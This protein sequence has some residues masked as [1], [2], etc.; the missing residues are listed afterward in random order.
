MRHHT[1]AAVRHLTPLLVWL[2]VPASLGA[3][4]KAAEAVGNA[5]AE[6]GGQANDEP[7]APRL[8]PDQQLGEKLNAYIDC[9][10]RT[11]SSTH[12]AIDQYRRWVDFEQGVTGKEKSVRGIGDLK[13]D[14]RC[15]EG[16][17]AA[18]PLPPADAELDAAADAWIL[19][20]K[21]AVP[22]FSTAHT[23]YHDEDYKDDG[24]A[25]AKEF[26]PQIAEA[27]KNFDAAD[28]ALR[29]VVHA[30]N[31][32][33][34]RRELERL[35][36]E[37]GRKLQFQAAN[38]MMHAKFTLEA[39]EPQYDD[40]GAVTHD[41]EATQAATD[42]FVEVLAEAEAY[43]EAHPKEAR[44]VV[45]MSMFISAAKAYRKSAKTFIRRQ[46]EGRPLSTGELAR[47]DAAPRT[48]D[49]TFAQLSELY[50]DLV[51][52]SNGISWNFY[53]PEG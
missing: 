14:T 34:A 50:N 4:D 28:M 25:K 3:C 7:A 10:N 37:T 17:E 41:L 2:T 29:K 23:Y 8:T 35:E 44:S 32:A 1:L 36:K 12:R 33:L 43:V 47:I 51:K 16:Y 11:S 52:R 38:V 9:L 31:D 48:V 40:Q 20:Y 6:Q 13:L 49:G 21:A 45:S 53:E 39:A 27:I 15:V 26:H 22:L 5:I 42:K 24:F 18:R 46:R 30:R 19:A